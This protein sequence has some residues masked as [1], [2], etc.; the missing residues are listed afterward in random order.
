MKVLGQQP[1]YPPDVGG[2]PRGQAWLSTASAGARLRAASALTKSADLSTV[3]SAAAADRVD[4]AG[5][6]LGIGAW[7]DRSA[8]AL[9]PLVGRPTALVAAAANTPEN[10]TS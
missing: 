3:E 9:R 7:T 1:F 2:W 6:L 4:A 10:L 5:Y 8:A